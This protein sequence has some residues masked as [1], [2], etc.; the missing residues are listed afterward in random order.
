[1]T[2]TLF[3]EITDRCNHTCFYC[4]KSFR[5]QPGIT[6]TPEALD[7]VL[8][9]PASGLVISGGEPSLAKEAVAYVLGR[10]TV[11]VVINTNL[12]CWTPDEMAFLNHRVRFN[13]SIPSANEGTFRDITGADTFRRVMDNLELADRDSTIIVIVH[14]R[15]REEL[16]STVNRLA[17]RGF[18]HFGFQPAYG[19]ASS[20]VTLAV[21]AIERV[22]AAY[23]HLYIKGIAP[24][25]GSERTP[26]PFLHRC[27]AGSG[28]LVILSDGSIVP[29]A[30]GGL[31]V[32]GALDSDVGE[33]F[34]SGESFHHSFPLERRELCKGYAEAACC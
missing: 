3:F 15:N 1:M 10:A 16:A 13:I 23:P 17:V 6:M 25:P 20:E 21:K 33:L 11:P 14:E 29:C 28:R 32:V 31:P 24:W 27:N 30:C 8:S 4:C 18:R 12:S 7:K 19:M 34:Q 9:L 2:R 5:G 26:V 22:W